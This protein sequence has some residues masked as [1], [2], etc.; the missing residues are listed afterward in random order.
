MAASARNL[1]TPD[2]PSG[3]RITDPSNDLSGGASSFRTLVRD[4]LEACQ[5]LWIRYH[6]MLYIKVPR[7]WKI[8]N[9]LCRRAGTTFLGCRIRR[10]VILKANA[11]ELRA[12]VQLNRRL[13]ELRMYRSEQCAL[14]REE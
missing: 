13:A 10:P 9:N 1:S 11:N 2:A 6:A 7:C 12:G 3:K 5:S 4:I 14:K 8:C